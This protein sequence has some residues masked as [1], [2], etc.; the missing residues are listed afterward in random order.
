MPTS[1]PVIVTAFGFHIVIPIL[2]R[3]LK[4]QILLLRLSLFLG[5]L[6]P[7]I[8]YC[9]W[10]VVIIGSIPFEG[11]FSLS[12][13]LTS[14]NQLYSLL[15]A[16]PKL[17]GIQGIIQISLFFCGLAIFTSLIGV[18]L[19]LWDFLRDGFSLKKWNGSQCRIITS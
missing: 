10:Q 5:S 13:I 8:I 9:I 16:M 14:K 1:L 2:A 17:T 18:S 3:Y 7:L 19:S 4:H 11:D 15:E 12:A 6:I